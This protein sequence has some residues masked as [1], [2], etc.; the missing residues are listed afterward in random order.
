MP[1]KKWGDRWLRII[2]TAD[3]FNEGESVDAG[4][5]TTV[6]VAQPRVSTGGLG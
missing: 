3:A 2:D 4:R 1:A 5:A 6:D